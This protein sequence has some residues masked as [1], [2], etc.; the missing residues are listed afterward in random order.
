MNTQN[1]DV[2]DHRGKIVQGRVTLV[3]ALDKLHDVQAL[4]SRR[5][6]EGIDWLFVDSAIAKAISLLASVRAVAITVGNLADPA[7]D[8]GDVWDLDDEVPLPAVSDIER[9]K[10]GAS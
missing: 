10:G 4:V 1:D 2:C 6:H 9:R 3:Q 8:D 5:N 7:F